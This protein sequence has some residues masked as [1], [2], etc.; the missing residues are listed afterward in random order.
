MLVLILVA[1]GL[2]AA[3]VVGGRPQGSP[4]VEVDSTTGAPPTAW[5]YQLQTY[6]DGGLADV[7]GAGAD[8]AVVDLARDGG[9]DWFTR[10]E[11]GQLRHAGTT[12][13]AYFE[14]GSIEDFRPEARTVRRDAGELVLNRLEEWP[15]EHFVAYWD[16]RWWDLVVRPRVD[17]A[18]AAGFDGVY[19]DTPLAYEEIDLELVPGTGRRELARRMVDLI[20]RIGEH[21]HLTDPDFLIVPQNSPE[22][23]LLPGYVDAIDGIGMEELFVLATDQLCTQEWCTV[24]LDHTRALRDAGKFVLA[25]DYADDPEL[26]ALACR[27]YAEEGF[28]GYVGPVGL[29]AVRP[30]RG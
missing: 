3:A 26:V 1:A 5:V 9:S 8:V 25:I 27:R 11:I 14:I 21:A 13:L 4:S 10:E 12:V 30:R 23:R 28:A 7:E 2:V 16:E 29:D 24:D 20:V 19:L 17:Q 6:H 15:D 22:L 18:L